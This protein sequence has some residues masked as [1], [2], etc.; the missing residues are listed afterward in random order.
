M[1]KRLK[2]K[3]E[4]SIK[5]SV[6]GNNLETFYHN[7]KEAQI[8]AYKGLSFQKLREE[9]S[10][11]RIRNADKIGELFEKFKKE[12]EKTGAKVYQAENSVDAC[13]YILSVCKKHNAEHVVKSKSMTAEEIGLNKYLESNGVKLVETDLGEWIIQLAGET[14]SHMIMPA[15]HKNRQQV[16]KLFKQHLNVEV[17]ED[18]IEGM[19]SI[20]RN[21]LREFYF[22][23]KVG[24]SGANVAVA[25]TG[26][27]GIVTNEGNGR[28]VTTIPPV[29]IVVLGYEKLVGSFDDALKILKVLPKNATGQ[30][31]SVYVSWIKGALNSLA[32]ESGKKELHFVFVDN[33][34]LNYLNN[35]ILKEAFKCIRCGSCANVCPV[36]GVVGGHVFGK[37]YTGP[38]GLI[39]TTLYHPTGDTKDLLSLCAGCKTCND[40][41]PAK[42]DIQGLIEKL[43]VGL[44][45]QYGINPAKKFLFSSILSKPVN[46]KGA[47]KIGSLILKTSRQDKLLPDKYNFR[48]LPEI[49]KKTFSE[50][51]KKEIKNP[52]NPEKRVFFYPGCA[53]EFLYPDVGISMAKLLVRM[54]IAIDIP[55]SSVCCGFPALHS[56]DKESAKKSVIK[57]LEY[58]NTPSDYDSY[59]VLCPTCGSMIKKFPDMVADIP[60]IY[61]VSNQIVSKLRMFS[62]F[63]KD[64]GVKVKADKNKKFT[65]HTP[66]HQI[67]GFGF[68]ADSFLRKI[69][70]DAFVELPDS[71]RCCGFGGSFSIDHPEIS[72]SILDKK[73]KS[74]KSTNVNVVVTEC[75]GCMIQIKGGIEKRDLPIEVIHISEL[76]EKYIFISK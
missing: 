24:I 32:S 52:K 8:K 33:G 71:D 31:M 49:S 59:V 64:L 74:I 23:A 46:L 5:D 22:R 30:V 68:S 29:H 28:L 26:T 72:A 75:P 15:I 13:E 1:H 39:L 67:R 14:P 66:C 54:N 19:V 42:V 56:G 61:R 57:A 9:V 11:L 65:Y 3:I 4:N 60:E 7:Y 2:E 18:D 21:Y 36:Y 62:E 48:K 44:A 73:I 55:T 17:D 35:S 70:E 6:L 43:N 58:M 41:C 51:F 76:F 69:L 63:I 12:V 10:S 50:R 47:A 37:I 25:E 38:I 40:I 16:A 34:R 53:I 45:E 20:A 27:I